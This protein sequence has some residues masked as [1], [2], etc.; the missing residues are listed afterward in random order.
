MIPIDHYII[1]LSIIVT[2]A[3]YLWILSAY[4][5]FT[6][7]LDLLGTALVIAFIV[8][9]ISSAVL[10]GYGVIGLSNQLSVYAFFAILLG[11][12]VKAAAQ[13]KSK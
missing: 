12:I 3:L 2:A 10:F 5:G 11:V 1:A 9:L 7:A 8:L 6:H 13:I 4:R